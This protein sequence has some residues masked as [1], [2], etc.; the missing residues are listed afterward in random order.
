MLIYFFFL[1]AVITQSSITFSKQTLGYDDSYQLLYVTY[2]SIGETVVMRHSSKCSIVQQF[3]PLRINSFS[4]VYFAVSVV[5]S[6]SVTFTVQRGY[7]HEL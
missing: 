3:V 1:E 6:S 7:A 4:V 5:R 2:I